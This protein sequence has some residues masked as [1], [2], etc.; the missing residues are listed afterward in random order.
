MKGGSNAG[1]EKRMGVDRRGITVKVEA[2][3]G[4][5]DEGYITVLR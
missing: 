3:D 1:E 4:K 5:G 2:E